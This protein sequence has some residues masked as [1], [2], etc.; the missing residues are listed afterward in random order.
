MT[1]WLGR[2]FAVALT[3]AALWAWGAQHAP[4]PEARLVLAAAGAFVLAWL[5]PLWWTVDTILGLTARLL[6]LIQTQVGDVEVEAI[7]SEMRNSGRTWVAVASD[8]ALQRYDAPPWAHAVAPL[9]WE[10]AAP[11]FRMPLDSSLT[12]I[13]TSTQQFTWRWR[14]RLALARLIWAMATILPP[15]A[16]AVYWW[17]SAGG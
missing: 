2:G 13:K 16:T 12:A 1:R 7:Y 14:R 9:F 3:A 8:W 17:L 10:V 4:W 5:A 6:K 15:S 11:L